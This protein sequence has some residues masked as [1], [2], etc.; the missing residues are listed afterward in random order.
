MGKCKTEAIQA[1]LGIFPN[2]LSIFRHIKT[3]PDIVSSIFRHIQ[4]LFRYIL[5][6]V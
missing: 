1:D 4:E 3:Y 2:V 6:P 5:N